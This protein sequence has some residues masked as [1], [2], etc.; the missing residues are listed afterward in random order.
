[1]RI[2]SVPID[3]LVKA[4]SGL[5]QAKKFSPAHPGPRRL[6]L[7]VA[8]LGMLVSMARVPFL[9]VVEAMG[10]EVRATSLYVTSVWLPCNLNMHQVQ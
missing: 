10:S 9:S 6:S 4:S 8:V 3:I 1:M 7:V 2:I 5:S